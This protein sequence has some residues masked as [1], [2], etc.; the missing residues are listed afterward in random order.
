MFGP[1][2]RQ[3]VTG[4]APTAR[5][6]MD[7]MQDIWGHRVIV[8]ESYGI[9]EAG[10]LTYDKSLKG[11]VEMRLEDWEEFRS[12]DKPHPRGELLVRTPVMFAGYYGRPTETTEAL[13]PDGFFRT[14]DIVEAFLDEKGQ[15]Y[16]VKVGS[17]LL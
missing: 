10:G 1:R 8:C 4:G 3:I 12:T 14:G 13:T 7:W 17:N 5:V 6:V 2:L 15:P 9:T 16:N 11:S